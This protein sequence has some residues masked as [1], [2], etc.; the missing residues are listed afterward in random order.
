[1]KHVRLSLI[2]SGLVLF[3]CVCQKKNSEHAGLESYVDYVN[4]FV[5]TLGSGNTF[6]GAVTPFGM[7]QISPDTEKHDWAAASGYEYADSTLLGFSLTHL[8][9]TGIPDLGDILF[10]PSIGDLS[11][12]PGNKADAGS[13]YRTHFTHAQEKASPGYYSVYLPEHDVN[14]EL[15]ASD[16]SGMLRFTFPES[17]SANIMTDLSHVLHWDVIWSNVRFENDSLVTGSHQVSGWAKERH[18]YFAAQYSRPFDS[19]GI[20][21]NGTSVTLQSTRYRSPYKATG[22]NLQFWVRYNTHDNDPIMVKVGISAIS[23]ANALMNLRT[24]IPHWNFQKVV[25]NARDKWNRELGRIEIEADDE[26]KRTFYTALYHTCLAPTI[27]EDVDGSYVGFDQNIHQSEDFINYDVFSLWDTYRALHPLYTLIQAERNSDMVNSM[28]AHFDQSADHLLPVWSLYSNETWTMIGYHAVPVIVDAYLK[29]NKGFDIHRAYEAIKATANTPDYDAIKEYCELGYV[30]FDITNE[31]VSKTLEYAF[32]D[33]CIAQLAQKLGK[34]EDYEYFKKRAYS[35]QNIFDQSTL[36]MRGKDSKGNWRQPFNPNVYQEGGDYT[37]GS[38][39]QYT[40]YVPHDAKGLIQ[41]MGG[42]RNFKKQLDTFFKT[43]PTAPDSPKDTQHGR[44]GQYWHGNEPS[45]HIAYLY[46]YVGQSWK[47]QERVHQIMNN[48]YGSEP[49]SLCGHDDCG[50]MSAWYVFNALGFYPVCPG[51][52]SY[53]WGS[54]N[55]LAA[56][57]HLS[58]GKKFEINVENYSKENIYIQSIL[59]NGKPWSNTYLPFDIID[60]GGEVIFSMG[61]AP[62]Y[63]F[64]TGDTDKPPSMTIESRTSMPFVSDGNQYFL[65]RTSIS[66]DCLDDDAIIRY[67]VDGSEPDEHSN[68]YK[69]ALNFDYNVII[70]AKAFHLHKKESLI[71]TTRITKAVLESSCSP[72]EIMPGLRYEYFEGVINNTDMMK[73][74]AHRG[75]IENFSLDLRQREENFGFVFSGYIQIPYDGIYTFYLTS[76]DGSKLYINDQLVVDNDNYHS[77]LQK[78]AK[79][80]LTSGIHRIMVKYFEGTVVQYLNLEWDGP[81]FDCR[82][83]SNSVLFH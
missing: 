14:V 30:P 73:I 1:M 17:D 6:P 55:V 50:Q 82:K 39:A 26:V 43:S 51:S 40:W 38:S 66:L 9:G 29:N 49:G 13:G 42:E 2:L 36:Y 15:T 54:P 23:T 56:V 18:L 68:V 64:G 10:V 79:I 63:Q 19:Y 65:N 44:I 67:T 61:S 72:S 47:T 34:T 74:P 78:S 21:K 52:D 32:D 57:M 16:R 24:E 31:S 11:F 83:V 70:R 80:A 59:I 69:R 46:N 22:K 60:R 5:G 58:N 77:T 71:L 76:D 45:H 3:A 27:Y 20:M 35:Y 81:G 53:V 62:N 41:I 7:I 4:P 25:T 37:Q 8:S 33:F 28:L 75:I 12:E 48:F